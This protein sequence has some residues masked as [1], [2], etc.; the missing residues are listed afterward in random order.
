L[1]IKSGDAG[2][3]ADADCFGGLLPLAKNPAGFLD[4]SSSRPTAVMILR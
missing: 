1:L 2:I 4:A 3:E